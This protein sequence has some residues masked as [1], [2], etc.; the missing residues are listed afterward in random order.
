MILKTTLGDI[1]GMD[2]LTV[3]PVSSSVTPSQEPGRDIDIF[4]Q[5]EELYQ[6]S[7]ILAQPCK[8][9]GEDVVQGL[10]GVGGHGVL[11]VLTQQRSRLDKGFEEHPVEST[12]LGQS[13]WFLLAGVLFAAFHCCFQV[14]A[15]N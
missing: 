8:R 3:H 10:G 13:G 15:D 4:E 6:R 14:R 9:R 7:R 1:V 2:L 12:S 11:Q 5:R